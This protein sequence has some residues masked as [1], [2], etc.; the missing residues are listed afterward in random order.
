VDLSRAGWRRRD[1]VSPRPALTAAE[2]LRGPLDGGQR[3]PET[4]ESA[5]PVGRE[6]GGDRGLVALLVFKF[7]EGVL[8]KLLPFRRF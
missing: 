8:R 4:L 3:E 2:F 7:F 1:A 6:Y 5:L